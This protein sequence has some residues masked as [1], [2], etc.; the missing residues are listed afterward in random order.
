MKLKWN[1]IEA[2]LSKLEQ[3]S[4]SDQKWWVVRWWM[5]SGEMVSGEVVNGQVHGEWSSGQV[6][7]GE[8]WDGEMVNGE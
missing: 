2:K 3:K 4:K 6:V 8:W 1:E 7:N 5:V